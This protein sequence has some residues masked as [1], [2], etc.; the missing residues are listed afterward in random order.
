[1]CPISPSL[2]PPSTGTT[3]ILRPTPGVTFQIKQD[4]AFWG[5]LSSPLYPMVQYSCLLYPW[6]LIH[7]FNQVDLDSE[8]MYME[9]CLYGDGVL[10][11]GTRSHSHW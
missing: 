5:W 11:A 3:H 9:S 4:H 2:L 10:K 8:F 1:M 6:L 7:R